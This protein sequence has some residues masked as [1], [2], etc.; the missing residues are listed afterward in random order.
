MASKS[1][2]LKN[3]SQHISLFDQSLL[4]T[5]SSKGLV[6]RAQK[7]LES[8]EPE[9]EGEEG[10]FLRLRVVDAFVKINEQGPTKAFCS[11]PSKEVC[12]H[13]LIACLWLSKISK[14]E[15]QLSNETAG[16]SRESPEKSQNKEIS[17]NDLVGWAG[18]K[19]VN[20]AFEKIANGE[21]VK[22]VKERIV[23]VTIPTVNI[24]CRFYSS[25]QESRE[26]FLESGICSCRS[27]SLCIHLVIAAIVYFRNLGNTL[28]SEEME[29]LKASAQTPRSRNE[30]IASAKILI[31]KSIE[32]G[33]CNLSEI[34]QER[35]ATLAVSAT[36]VNLPRLSAEVRVIGEQIGLALAKDAKADQYKLL[37]SMTRT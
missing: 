22:I 9:I 4:E 35:F 37:Q 15:N 33:I 21:E 12:R 30:V 17:Y 13:I 8:I 19:L 5:I 2:L 6:R 32:I 3:L 20:L 34:K 26:K 1:D 11:C 14:T 7:D 28:E 16:E 23:T 29:L 10:T 24:T 36:G 31:E 25:L 18:K 27:S